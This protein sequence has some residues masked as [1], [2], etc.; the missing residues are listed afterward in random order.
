VLALYLEGRVYQQKGMYPQAIADFLRAYALSGGI[1]MTV[2][3]LG[4]AYALS[5]DRTQARR[6]LSKLEELSR[7]RYLS[8]VYPMA[9]CAMLGDNEQAFKWLQKA[10]NDRS[11][12]LV[13][14]SKEPGMESFQSDPRFTSIMSQIGVPS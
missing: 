6:Q 5:G 1:P 4:S 13:Y 8:A 11:N 3:A 14:L 12:Y 9:V 7:R 10:Y 2:M